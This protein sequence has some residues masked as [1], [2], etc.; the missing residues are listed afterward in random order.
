MKPDNASR[1]LKPFLPLAGMLAFVLL[2][3]GCVEKADWKAQQRSAGIPAGD[4]YASHTV[5]QIFTPTRNGLSGVEVVLV[6]YGPES[7][8]PAVPLDLYLCRDTT[9]QEAITRTTILPEEQ[10]HNRTIRLR[11]PPQNDSAG[12]PY[13]L[14]AA[15]P[16]ADT[17]SRTTLWAHPSDLYPEGNL[18]RDGRPAAGDLNFWTFYEAGIGEVIQG[19]LRQA[20]EGLFPFLGL[21]LLLLA[22][23]Y[24]LARLL[25][26]SPKEDPLT[27]L[28]TCLAMSVAAIPV[29]LLLLS[30]TPFRL[31][32]WAVRAGGVV[33]FLLSLGLVLHDLRQG[34]WR[35]AFRGER[36]H[37][38]MPVS[39]PPSLRERG[40]LPLYLWRGNPYSGE[41]WARGTAAPLVAAAGIVGIGLV[42]RAVHALDL[43]GP[44]WV[45]AVH[46]ALVAR[47]IVERGA[48]PGDYLPYVQVAPATYHFGFQSLAAVLHEMVG[49]PIPQA[50]LLVGQVLSGLSGLPLYV[51]GKRWG[52]NVWAGLGAAMVPSAL[53]LL[54]AYLVSWSRY[55]ELAG[56]FLL[57]VGAVLLE[58]LFFRR[59]WHW[60]LAGASAVLLAG[61]LLTHLQ[62]AAFLAVLA[63]LILLQATFRHRYAARSIATLW[64]RAVGVGLAAALLTFAWLLPSILH[65]WLPA[66][67][68]WPAA[69][70]ETT[71]YYILFG[72]GKPVTWVAALGAAMALLRRRREASLLFFWVGLLPILARPSFVGLH[73]GG[74]V[75]GLAVSIALYT[76]LALAA[77]LTVGGMARALSPW[78]N[79]SGLRWTGAL[80]LI[81]ICLWGAYELRNVVH[82]RTA[83]LSR[84]DLEAI[85]WI[86]EHTPPEALFLINSYEWMNA[87]YAGSD[88]GAWIAPLTGRRTWPPPALYG[89]GESAYIAGINEV[90][91]EAMESPNGGTLAALMRRHGITHVYLGRYGGALAPEKLLSSPDF[92]LLYQRDGV[93]V[94]ALEPPAR[95]EGP[96]LAGYGGN[97]R[98]GQPL[99]LPLGKAR[100][101]GPNRFLAA[102]FHAPYPL[103]VLAHRHLSAFVHTKPPLKMRTVPPGDRQN[104]FR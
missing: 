95:T 67:R 47:L 50:L 63:F 45:D 60:G 41:R 57:P 22:P 49:I 98:A 14:L 71:L 19:L 51:L 39:N 28:G 34:R 79:A 21:V 77:A 81:G 104:V 15:A 64:G 86:E 12:R 40:R 33:L 3:I 101:S 38:Y 20:G 31:S 69:T 26:P 94:F 84:A 87:V 1:T 96:V 85:S 82:A 93:W 53:S 23:G 46:H 74:V 68:Q 30:Q 56:L 27:L 92:R 72:P 75:D 73:V 4:L 103:P 91:Q 52:G 18:L 76:P 70:D 11:C 37:P 29:F 99:Q 61:L 102:R 6:D 80:L 7:G 8:R 62:V 66:L 36:H 24:L 16:Q 54:P 58:R 89:L 90:A 78:H 42:L 59:S 44:L 55:T 83:L 9:C 35:W 32:P 100:G 48:I 13:F 2:L 5:G 43:P 17:P 88:G 65:L 25:P 10:A 97:R